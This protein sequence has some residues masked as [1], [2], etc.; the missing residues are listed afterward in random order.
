MAI[1]NSVTIRLGV[2]G[3]EAVNRALHDIGERGERE[4]SRAGKAAED[5]GKKFDGLARRLDP[6]ARAT[7]DLSK[8]QEIANAA[9]KS[10]ARSAEEAAR[11]VDLAAERQK[12]AAAAAG[13][14]GKAVGLAR[15]EWINL[16]RQLQDTAVSLQGGMS[17]LTVLA[18]QGSQVFDVLST[19][20]TGVGG[21]LRD[22]IATTARFAVR[23]APFAFIAASA[24]EAVTAT[25]RL[26]AQL[27]ALQISIN[28]GGA[29]SGLTARQA[30]AIADR[31]SGLLTNSTARGLAGQFLGAGVSGGA[32]GG[33]IA[34]TE[35]FSRRMGVAL[36]DAAKELSAALADPAKGAEELGKKYGLVTLEQ[37]KHIRQTAAL[38]QRSAATA[39]L[40]AALTKSVDGLDDPTWRVS[41]A[42]DAVKK[43]IV[44]LDGAIGRWIEGAIKGEAEVAR[45]EAEA[46][47]RAAERKARAD[48]DAAARRADDLKRLRDDAALAVREIQARTY[49]EREAVAVERARTE[50]MRA[51]NDEQ[52]AAIAAER[53]RAVMAAEARKRSEEVLRDAKAGAAGMRLDPLERR[54]AEIDRKYADLNE[55]FAPTNS[56]AT[57]MARAFDTAGSAANNLAV[58]LDGAAA[59]VRGQSGAMPPMLVGLRGAVRGAAGSD[60]RGVADYIRSRAMAYG[61]DPN[62][63]LRVA[64]SEGLG[65]FV[66]DEG[67]SFGAFQL[68]V[69]GRRPG[70]LGA[71]GLGDSFRAATG[72]DPSNPANERATI[73]FALKMAARQG[74]GAW[75][76][77]KRIGI[78]GFEGIG[79]MPSA[80]GAVALPDIH[81][82]GMPRRGSNDNAVNDNRDI[83]GNF[84]EAQ[85]LEREAAIYEA[86]IKPLDEFGKK[87][88]QEQALLRT[89]AQLF[90]ADQRVVDEAVK[91]Q[92]LMNDA[93]SRSKDILPEQ[94]R[95]IDESAAAWARHEAAVRKNNDQQERV[96]AV[97]D[98]FRDAARE[99]GNGIAS[100]LLRGADAG[101]VLEQALGRVADR[102]L[103]LVIDGGINALFGKSG[104]LG[105][106]A[107]G[108]GLLKAIGSIFGFA[109][110]GVMTSRGPVPL[111]R[112]AMGGVANSPQLAMFGEGA[113]PEAYVPLQDGRTIP[114][115]MRQSAAPRGGNV[116]VNIKNAP[117]DMRRTQ[118]EDANGDRFL[119]FEFPE[120]VAAA[121]EHPKVLDARSRTRGGRAAMQRF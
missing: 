14:H 21:A 94:Q 105:G 67:T 24:Y 53:A 104:T 11:V 17:P 34:L 41:D 120:M 95:R 60:P 69:G 26:Q 47:R 117:P 73:D 30:A 111:R 66:G 78:T 101:K 55:Q 108:G 75:N 54:L 85:R 77:A 59:A 43:K 20:R 119:E 1:A 113:R 92:E 118:R 112:Y 3:D 71:S 90:G 93:L 58:A 49:A 87:L 42:F 91:R 4:L 7:H 72:L 107:L 84:A 31:N 96:A 44:D 27:D 98:T 36:D 57:P 80:A 121:M 48:A 115:T 29:T 62:V 82:A 114:V 64:R 13:E 15:H 86:R 110:G 32:L 2:T 74:W 83:R 22:I 97:Y 23:A 116:Y 16:S 100:A 68:H 5:A 25:T 35:Q 102:L 89:R 10:G 33:S 38:G 6:L 28:R 76:G 88:Q 65:E 37:E 40:L 8:A 106:G 63:A 56:P 61:I 70:P 50:A 12:R 19:S 51:T 99:A 18:Q 79:G 9:V 81:V 39:E 52:K 45:E 46:Q 103:S 109:D